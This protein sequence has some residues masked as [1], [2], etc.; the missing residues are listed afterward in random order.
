MRPPEHLTGRDNWFEDFEPGAV[1]RHARGKTVTD[2]EGVLL[3]HLV[4]NTAQAHFNEDAMSRTELGRTLV[5]GGVVAALV[6]GLAMQDTGENALRELRLEGVRFRAPVRHGDTLYAYSEV[7]DKHAGDRPEAGV[8]HFRHAGV[9]Q[10]GATV[11]ECDRWVLV[12]RRA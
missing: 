8:V 4:L 12:R 11:F 10:A 5:F 6:I 3:T 2:L 1:Y 7:V 9:N